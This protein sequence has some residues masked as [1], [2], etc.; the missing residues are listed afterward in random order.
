[1]KC[2]FSEVDIISLQTLVSTLTEILSV[3]LKH[4]WLLIATPFRDTA[5]IPL[6]R[7]GK[8]MIPS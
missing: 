2:N 1:M 6:F 7:L 3:L 4:T 8:Q 5:G